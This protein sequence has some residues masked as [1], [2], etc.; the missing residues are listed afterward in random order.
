MKNKRLLARPEAP[1]LPARKP[2]VASLLGHIAQSTLR[3]GMF[4]FV[5]LGGALFLFLDANHLP[6]EH[7]PVLIV[8]A[9]LIIALLRGIRV[10]Q[11]DLENYQRDLTEYRMSLED[12]RNRRQAKKTI[13]W[14]RH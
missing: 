2:G 14:N 5:C 9:V 11:D 3:G 1:T 8:F 6:A 7:L 13:A 12:I 4:W 10:W